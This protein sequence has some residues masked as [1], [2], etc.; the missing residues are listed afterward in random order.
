MMRFYWTIIDNLLILLVSSH[1]IYP[2]TLSNDSLI[3][4]AVQTK[5]KRLW[6]YLFFIILKSVELNP[7]FL[8]CCLYIYSGFS[9]AS[10][11]MEIW[12]FSSQICPLSII[13]FNDGYLLYIFLIICYLFSFVCSFKL[14]YVDYHLGIFKCLLALF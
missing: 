10:P 3:I 12:L 9:P 6:T 13:I 1:L 2:S 7:L 4:V 5:V 11:A 14:R 8:G